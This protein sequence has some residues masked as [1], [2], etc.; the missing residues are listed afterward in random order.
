M[1]APPTPLLV[2]TPGGARDLP[3]HA[4]LRDALS[5]AGA[6]WIETGAACDRPGDFAALIV[7]GGL[8]IGGFLELDPARPGA[9]AE[10]PDRTIRAFHDAGRWIG[11]PGVALAVVLQALSDEVAAGGCLDREVR[12]EVA[13]L[14]R[15]RV[16]TTA[17]ALPARSGGALE[18]ALRD[19][20]PCLVQAAGADA[21]VG[22][23][24]ERELF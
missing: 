24:A 10:A 9:L 4:A 13:I 11:A 20:V 5:K 21:F 8:D 15:L 6:D 2:L 14:P 3:S 18:A 7:A 19:F 22:R 12:Q 16:V 23:S 1:R 17:Q